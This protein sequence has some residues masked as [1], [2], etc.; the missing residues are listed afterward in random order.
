MRMNGAGSATPTRDDKRRIMDA[1]PVNRV[2]AGLEIDRVL[3]VPRIIH[4]VE[5]IYRLIDNV[6]FAEVAHDR[7]RHLVGL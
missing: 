4:G 5:S 6:D 2:P 3:A 7:D 1:H